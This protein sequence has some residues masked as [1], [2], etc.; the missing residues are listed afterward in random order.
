MLENIYR[1]IEE[2][3]GPI[4]AAIFGARQVA[5]AIIATTLTLAAVFLP[6]AFQSGQTGRLFFEFGITLAVS[7]LVSAFVALTLTPM[8]CSRVLTAKVVDGQAKHGWFY[9]KT[10]PFFERM[11]GLFER[12]LRASLRLK[13]AVL[14][15]AL[16]FTIGGVSLYF[17]LQREL[18]PVED[19]G[20]FTAN[21]I[22]P[23]G[24]TPEYLRLYS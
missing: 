11:N 23:I 16:V 13:P 18:T 20:I 10:E 17:L 6:V 7:V 1:R 24:A 12:T 21:L 22:A 2:G 9:N 14:A 4:H 3:E 19:R 8:L 15:G 5:F